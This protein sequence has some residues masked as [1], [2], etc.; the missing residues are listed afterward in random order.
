MFMVGSVSR[1]R[2]AQISLFGPINRLSFG[3]VVV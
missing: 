3:E 1:Q 2:F